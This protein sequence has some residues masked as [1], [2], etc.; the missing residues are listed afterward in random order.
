MQASREFKLIRRM[1]LPVIE[2]PDDFP[3]ITCLCGSTQF[4]QEFQD[5]AEQEILKNHIVLS[6]GIPYREGHPLYDAATPEERIAVKE[7]LDRLHKRKIDLADEILVLN[8]D[9]YIGDSTRGEIE[10]ALEHNKPVRY[11]YPELYPAVN[12]L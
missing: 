1:R 10:Y 12:G 3:I 8:V 11:Q 6:V 2:M 5:V 7:R 4:W 9:G